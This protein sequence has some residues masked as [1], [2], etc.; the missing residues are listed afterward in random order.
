LALSSTDIFSKANARAALTSHRLDALKWRFLVELD[1]IFLLV[2]VLL[3]FL[4]RSLAF[5]GLGNI[6]TISITEISD[7]GVVVTSFGIS[8][9][10]RLLMFGWCEG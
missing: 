9:E 3:A 5:Q 7:A 8:V 4:V 6:A 2:V 1:C 10:V